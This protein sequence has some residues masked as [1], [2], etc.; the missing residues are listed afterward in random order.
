MNR[1]HTDVKMS[2][3]TVVRGLKMM[4][5]RFQKGLEMTKVETRNGIKSTFAPSQVQLV[6][7]GILMLTLEFEFYTV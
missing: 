7:V 4:L 5:P 2:Q 3:R 1:G 6:F